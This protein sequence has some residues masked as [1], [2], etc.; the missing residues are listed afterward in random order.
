MKSDRFIKEHI[1]NLSGVTRG[2][3]DLQWTETGG[4]VSDGGE[5]PHQHPGGKKCASEIA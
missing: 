5:D 3:P 2:S 4:V 1:K